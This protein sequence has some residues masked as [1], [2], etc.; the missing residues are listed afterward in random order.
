MIEVYGT[1][2]TRKSATPRGFRAL[3]FHANRRMTLL[4]RMPPLWRFARSIRSRKWGG[5]RMQRFPSTGLLTLPPKPSGVGSEGFQAGGFC[6][7]AL[8]RAS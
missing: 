6:S 3:S 1:F 4:V 5:R 8:F 2:R 7:S